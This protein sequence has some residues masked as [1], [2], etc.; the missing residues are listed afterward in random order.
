MTLSL[1]R[2]ALP[3]LVLAASAAS[4]Q[5]G[6]LS[7]TLTEAGTGT[8]LVGA[9]VVLAPTD[10]VTASDA[11]GRYAFDDV[12]A[13]S[14]TITVSS[15]GYATRRAPVAV[16]AGQTVRLDLAL[17]RTTAEVGEVV[18]EGRATNLVGVASSASEG[19]AGREQI[20]LRPLLRVGE[21]L[22]TVPGAVVTQ[23]SG[24]GKANQFFLRGFNL[25]HGTDFAASLDGLPLN[26][27]THAHGQGYLDVNTII[28]ELVETVGF[29][30]GPQ[31]AVTGNFSTAGR[32]EISYVRQLSSGIAQVEGG[33]NDRVGALFANSHAVGGGDVLYGLR[34]RYTDGPWVNSENS[35]L[36]SAIAKYST[37]TGRDGL[38]VTATG[39]YTDWDATDQV[40]IRA[41]PADIPRLGAADPTDGGTTGRYALAGT[42]RR[43][44]GSGA[45]RATAYA[46]AYHLDLFSNFTYFLD[47]PDRGDQF[48]QS[49]RRVYGGADLARDWTMAV[50]QG[51][52][53]TLGAQLRHDQIIDVGLHRTDGRQR[54]STV[55]QDDVAETAFGVY[56]QN[57]T[58]WTPTL[59]T[60]V[61]LR[62]DALR[63]DVSSDR[64]I[65]SGDT[66]DLI[67]SPKA[68]LALE[69]WAQT[70]V[71][72]NAGFGF[73]SNDARGTVI[74]VDPASGDPVDPVDP[75]VRT[76]AAEVGVR[77]S[78]LSGLETTL[79]LWAIGLDSE[80]VFVGDA[81]GTEASDASRHLGVEWT[82]H[83]EPLDWLRMT[84]DVALTDSRFTEGDDLRIENSVGR[85]VTGGVYAGRPEGWVA[86]VQVRHLGPRPLS[87]DG[88]VTS[89]AS[90]LVN[91]RAGY[92]IGPVGVTLDVL[93]VFDSEAADVSYFY[94]SRLPGES[95]AGVED[96]HVHPVIPRTAR[97]TV[98]ARF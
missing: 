2:L 73:H 55:R 40:P 64:D 97:L 93:N 35:G 3:L 80:L 23:H 41:V 56:A 51:A 82:N 25:D 44:V 67:L 9:S 78:A 48:E 14:Y 74:A 71:Y 8:P 54:L 84:L 16:L 49:E 5:P 95:A 68:G 92:R 27:P 83:Y 89:D 36:V 17:D 50:G 85:V 28:P 94:T 38:T 96:V 10:R 46:A 86:S 34:A 53:T 98:R 37:G 52:T 4:A 61:G 21:V 39:F 7:G 62:A 58:R 79:A 42:F 45:L 66:A 32:A 43:P 12:P 30:K 24:S 60:L 22:E 70:E 6:R 59:R 87:G 91:A 69:P 15:V 72:F 20:A 13:G 11:R 63:F 47:D 65:N 81:G 19:F 75:L 26:L 57:E 33:L 31:D 88:A 29:R 18:V 90:T 77:S 1:R 76:R